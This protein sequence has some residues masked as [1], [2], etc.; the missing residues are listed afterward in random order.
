LRETLDYYDDG[1]IEEGDLSA[2]SLVL[3]QFRHAVSDAR[4][5][6]GATLSDLQRMRSQ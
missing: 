4:I 2:M 6:I 3:E 1:A 5:T